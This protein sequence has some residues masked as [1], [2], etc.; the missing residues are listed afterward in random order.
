MSRVSFMLYTFFFSQHSFFVEYRTNNAN[1]ENRYSL[2]YTHTYIHGYIRIEFVRER[3]T[4][5]TLNFIFRLVMFFRKLDINWHSSKYFLFSLFN[6]NNEL[7]H[8]T[9]SI[10]CNFNFFQLESSFSYTFMENNF[11]GATT[12]TFLND[13]QSKLPKNLIFFSLFCTFWFI[14]IENDRF[15]NLKTCFTIAETLTNDHF[16]NFLCKK[17]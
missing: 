17:Y 15:S 2:T 5:H 4:K 1:D 8:S 10:Q 6:L 7:F 16:P 3:R 9:H 14:R 13:L 12:Q 11:P